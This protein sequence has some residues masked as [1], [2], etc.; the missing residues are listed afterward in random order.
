MYKEY[1]PCNLLSPYIDKYWEIEGCPDFGTRINILPD[2]CTDFIFTLGG[3]PRAIHSNL[4]MRP[5]QA[6]F[7]GPM[8]TYSEL[9]TDTE[10]IHM[11]GVRFLPCGLSHFLEL[12]LHELTNSRLNA[13]ELPTLFENSFTERLCEQTDLRSRINLIESYLIGY[14]YQNS[15]ASNSQIIYAINQINQYK[16]ILSIQSLVKDICLCQR[17]FERKF[18]LNTG[19]TPK[20]Y[21]R[22]IKFRNA[23]DLLRTESYENLLSIAIHA[24]YYDVPH[25]SREIKKM[26]G[27]TA[28]SF[29]AIPPENE[30]GFIYVE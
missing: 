1:Q 13:E 7:V 22:I 5:C 9:V 4:V 2:G 12:P 15:Q 6:Y 17:H 14:L 3:A 8:N 29:L 23:V 21:S 10:S 19:F 24:G 28:Y 16:G 25:L 30:I 18:K 20:E 11:I 27:S 26:S